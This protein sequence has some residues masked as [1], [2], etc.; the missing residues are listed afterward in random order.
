M[1]FDNRIK[2][3]EVDFDVGIGCCTAVEPLPYGQEVVL[4]NPAICWALI[5]ISLLHYF[6]FSVVDSK[7]GLLGRCN[8]TDFPKINC[9]NE[10][11]TQ[12]AQN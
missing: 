12:C 4:L 10:Q 5:F 6:F 11:P 2:S 8:V 9:F 3:N 1:S 7:T